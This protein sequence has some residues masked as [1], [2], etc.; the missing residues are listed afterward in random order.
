MAGSR[1]GTRHLLEARPYPA[2]ISLVMPLYNEGPVVDLMREAMTKFL[3]SLPAAAEVV[4]VNDGSQDDT[5][6]RLVAW[7]KEDARVHVLQLSRNFGH[8]AA[9]TAGLEYASG[10]AVVLMDGDLQDPLETIHGMVERYQEGYEVVY[11]QRLERE[12]ESPFKK[13]TAWAF[14]RLMRRFVHP[15]LPVDAGD[16]RLM[17]RACLDDLKRLGETHRFLRGMV[18]WLGYPQCAQPYR[19]HARRAGETKY[20]L[21]K[22]ITFAWTAATSFSDLPLRLSGY[23][24][25]VGILLAIEEAFRALL[26]YTLGWYVVSGWTTLV[27][28]ISF[29]GGAILLCLGVLGDYVGKIYIEVKGRPVY[30]VARQ[31]HYES[32]SMESR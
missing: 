3:P 8:Q 5:I 12:G 16:F 19:R 24:G 4:L 13:L 17:G 11:G 1:R 30:L 26:A 18:T 7:A 32:A 20:P 15:D 27:I 31:Y 2:K 25:L 6:D 28:L 23:L 21:R 14:Y 9:A 29:L 22:M 10:D